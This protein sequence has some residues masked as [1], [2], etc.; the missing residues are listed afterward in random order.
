MG[1]LR[2]KSEF[3]LEAAKVLIDVHNYYAP[4]VHCSYYACFQFIKSKL[5]RIGITYLKMDADIASQEKLSSNQYPIDLI[6]DEL[7][8]KTDRYYQRDVKT[9]IKILKAYRVMS[10]YHNEEVDFSKGNA[11][12]M[13]SKDIISLID[14]K[15]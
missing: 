15:L 10:D 2:A 14:K 13:L 3:N 9:K 7:G 8:K 1:Q 4:S 6:I 5:N 11:A 12:L